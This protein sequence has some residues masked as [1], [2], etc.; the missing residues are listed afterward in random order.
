[1]IVIVVDRLRTLG[2]LCSHQARNPETKSS[3]YCESVR[4][5][6]RIIIIDEMIFDVSRFEN[7]DQ[8]PRV[9]IQRVL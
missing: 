3:E 1:M 4:C 5:V 7:A 8:S 2:C 6:K 9:I